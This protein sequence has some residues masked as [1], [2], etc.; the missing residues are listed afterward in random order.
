MALSTLVKVVTVLSV[1]ST[2]LL[3]LHPPPAAELR[4]EPAGAAAVT[5]ARKLSQSFS[6]SPPS[7]APAASPPSPHS[8]PPRSAAFAPAMK[9]SQSFS[10]SPPSS[11]PAASPP[12]PHS[13][14][15]R[16][17]AVT[18]ANMSSTPTASPLSQPPSPSVPQSPLSSSLPPY[19]AVF[20]TPSMA[21]PQVFD[22]SPPGTDWSVQHHLPICK[23]V[24][25]IPPRRAA[26]PCRPV[27][28]VCNCVCPPPPQGLTAPAPAP[29]TGAKKKERHRAWYTNWYLDALVMVFLYMAVTTVI[30]IFKPELLTKFEE[31]LA[32]ARDE[33]KKWI[34]GS[35]K[36]LAVILWH[37]V[38][39]VYY[40]GF[41]VL[42]VLLVLYFVSP[43]ID[44][45][46]GKDM[47]EPEI[48]VVHTLVIT[49]GDFFPR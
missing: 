36:P 31:N 34:E 18:P 41:G 46:R 27:P 16:R 13:P 15:P 24:C 38:R 9:L 45:F 25:P 17:A 44:Y 10:T 11:A 6:I 3:L 5:L 33:C 48:E 35:E 12:S 37:N 1:L 29:S 40:A 7:S 21:S 28:C 19:T 22:R 39:F 8:P 23:C 14:P 32:T 30:G 2:S 26:V 20:T 4:R 42:S 49:L 43:V 47:R